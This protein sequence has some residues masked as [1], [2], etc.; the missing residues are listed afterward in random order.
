M[1]LMLAMA[2]GVAMSL[3][4]T[5]TFAQN[6]RSDIAAMRAAGLIGAPAAGAPVGVSSH[7]Q[8]MLAEKLAI[9]SRLIASALADGETSADHRMWLLETMYRTP[10]EQ[11]REMGS[12]QGSEATLR[13]ITKA[14]KAP[15][16]L[17]AAS[18]ELVYYPI[19]P[20][21]YIDTRNMGGPLAAPRGFNLANTGNSYGGS[22]ACDPKSTVGGSENTIGAVALN[23]AIVSPTVA[24]GFVGVRPAGASTSTAL[25]N[26]Y[27]AGPSVQ[28]SNAGV[29][30]TNQSPG[31]VDEIE[32]FGSPTQFIVDVFGV[33]AAPTATQ[34]D[35]TNG[36]ETNVTVNT[37]SRNFNLFANACAPGYT[38]VSNSC[39]AEG[40]TANG[41]VTL[42]GQGAFIGGSN[43]F[44]HYSGATS[45]NIKNTPMCC[46]LPGR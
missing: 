1:R 45:A 10:L 44:G 8:A 21:R 23:V 11:L 40:D 38:M 30:S 15:R 20:C 19:T 39:Q 24:P 34:L 41:V 3:G 6:E 4:A 12:T 43:C 42:A 28:A 33:F 36:T 17:G 46:R 31:T 14:A 13:A 32:F 26:W 7:Q 2:A 37:V 22:A 29:V 25:V 18:T 27:L 5:G 16:K 9:A 35:C